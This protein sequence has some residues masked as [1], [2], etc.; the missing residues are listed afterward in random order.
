MA[1]MPMLLKNN[2]IKASQI[3]GIGRHADRYDAT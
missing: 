3:S 2:L 1:D